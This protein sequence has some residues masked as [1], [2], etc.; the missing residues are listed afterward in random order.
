MVNTQEGN[1]FKQHDRHPLSAANLK[2]GEMTDKTQV[3]SPIFPCRHFPYV[4]LLF[5]ITDILSLGRG[6][7][8]TEMLLIIIINIK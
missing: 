8:K 4:K 6:H 7:R 2:H 3:S 5:E 1:K